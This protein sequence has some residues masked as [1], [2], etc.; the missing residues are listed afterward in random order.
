MKKARR[1]LIFVLCLTMI[2]L[3]LSG[4][5][6]KENTDTEDEEVTVSETKKETKKKVVEEVQEE[7]PQIEEEMHSFAERICGKYSCS[8]SDGEYEILE[9]V[10]FADNIYAYAGEAYGDDESDEL[11]TYSFW[12]VEFIPFSEE[13]VAD[14]DSDECDFNILCFSIMSNA[15]KYWGA[16]Q[17]VKLKI[18][19]DGL[20]WIAGDEGY[21]T[22]Y[23]R[24]ERVAGTFPYMNDETGAPFYMTSDTIGSWKQIDS[25]SVPYYIEFT[26]CDNMRIYRKDPAS[27]VF[28]ACGG[29]NFDAERS[30]WV[31]TYSVLGR[32]DMPESLAFQIK[33]RGYVIEIVPDEDNDCGIDIFDSDKSVMFE[34]YR[35]YYR[36]G[37]RNKVDTITNDDIKAAGIDEDFTSG[38][39]Y[40]LPDVNAG[41][42]GVWVSAFADEAD[43][44]K[45]K[46]EL[47]DNGFDSVIVLSSEWS[48]MN[49]KPFY[50]VS[51][52]RC[53]SQ[54]EAEGLLVNVK[55]AGYK[56]A[57]VKYTGD[58][59][60][61]RVYYT[62]YSLDDVEVSDSKVTLNDF[63]ISDPS[64]GIDYTLT[65]T[66]DDKTEFDKD[67]ETEFF[68]NY[69]EGDT[70]LEWYKRNYDYSKNDP[71]K[72]MESG[73]ALIGVFEVSITDGHIDR[74]YGSYWWD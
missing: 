45:L 60:N 5:G 54:T 41:F 61:N 37:E 70:P 46:S 12:A 53:E 4:C 42:Y 11:D 19:D 3:T 24:D 64:L 10:N 26:T 63:S 39:D 48:E 31:C 74:F 73:P 67:C 40:D 69:E 21:T 55:S 36:A 22:H 33:V 28:L 58:R 29:L 20:D 18:T 52:G 38:I 57:Y 32:G 49:S 72:Y 13:S 51:A 6:S 7:P 35:P 25:A 30:E 66:I 27:E 56:D 62:C 34:L 65:L 44:D 59:L 1:M 17:K 68:A 43:A 14:T 9:I 15:G 2:F 50:C 23:V 71:D 16:P 47:D 8:L